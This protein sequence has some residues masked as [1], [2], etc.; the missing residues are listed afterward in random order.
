MTAAR[1]VE[2]VEVTTTRWA[3]EGTIT[4]V[5]VCAVVEAVA[6]STDRLE[7]GLAA[8]AAEGWAGWAATW[9]EEETSEEG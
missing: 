4:W 1:W 6:G 9:A 7:E 5:V 8:A 3:V 2:V